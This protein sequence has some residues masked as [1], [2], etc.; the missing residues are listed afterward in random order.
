MGRTQ[1]SPHPVATVCTLMVQKGTLLGP[2]FVFPDGT[3]LTKA[4]FLES[5]KAALEESGLLQEQLIG[6]ASKLELT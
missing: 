2:F 4:R 3:P 5:V 1:D 6:V